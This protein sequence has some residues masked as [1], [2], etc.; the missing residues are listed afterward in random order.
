[1]PRS[2]GLVPGSISCDMLQR[3]N[4][5]S[6]ERVRSR[7]S[8][9]TRM[10]TIAE[11]IRRLKPTPVPADP[12]HQRLRAVSGFAPNPGAL[13][14]W[15][16]VP[17]GATAMALVVVLHGCTQT[18]ASYDH[19][20]GWSD[21]A[22][23]YGFAVLFPE[24]NRANNP[25]LCFNWFDAEDTRR[26]GGEAA[27]IRQM[28]AAMLAQH[29]ID[30]ARVFVT[31][32]SAGGAMAS[33]MLATYPEMFAGGGIIA[34]LPYGAAT[35]VPQALA[36][37]RDQ[38]HPDAATYVE[39][40]RAASAHQ[41]PWPTISVWHGDADA[42]VS[43]GNAARIV[44]QWRG[45]HGVGAAPDLTETIGAHRRQVWL[46]RDGGEAIEAY[47]IAGMGHGTPL[48]THGAD[49]CGVAGPHMLEA[50]I[51]STRR[52]AARWGLL[53]AER[54]VAETPPP[55]TSRIVA[56]PLRHG[57]A[58]RPATPLLDVRATIENALRGAGLMR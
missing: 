53:G 34:G 37:M 43:A 12:G 54:S 57:G 48:M 51:S 28:I 18:A 1:M 38:G 5:A 32:L 58:P 20:S 42:T 22:D 7:P 52:L 17:D 56:E 44:A 45:L 6:P 31:G 25:N 13:Q 41:G 55:A 29:P 30:P 50:G 23:R 2:L 19:G 46:D 15:R 14:G 4:A 21:L 36:R 3:S 47:S 11:T 8:I 10:S 16:H 33:V 35:S 49:G 26:D 9:G 40:V 39:R 24:Q 27:S